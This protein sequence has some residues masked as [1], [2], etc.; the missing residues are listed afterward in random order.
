[1]NVEFQMRA[2]SSIVKSALSGVSLFSGGGIGDLALRACNIDVLVGSELLTD[3]AEI[4]K[5]NYPETEMI[6]GDILRTRE[7]ILQKAKEKLDGRELDVLFATPPCQGMSKNGRGKLLN[8]IR[9]GTKPEFDVR[10]QLALEA[11]E[12]A[13]VLKPRMIVFEN[14][15][16][17]ANTLIVRKDGEVAGLLETLADHLGPEYRGQW[18]VVE[19]ADYG[20]PERRQRLITVFSREQSVKQRIEA[21]ISLIAE[22]THSAEPTIFTKRWVSV[23]EALQG[24]PLLDASTCDK[25][26]N[27]ELEFHRVPVLDAKKYFWVSNTPMGSGA[28]DN[29][30]VNPECMYQLNPTHGAAHDDAGINRSKKDTPIRCIQCGALLPRPWVEENGDYRLMSGFTSA[31]RRMRGDLPASAL[32]K[33]LA[34][35]CS[36]HKLH[37][38]EHRVLSL[39]EAFV[40]HTVSQYPFKWIRA[41][42][43]RVT[44]TTI[45]EI[46]GESIPPKGLEVLFHH[47]L[48]ILD[49]EIEV[50]NL[51]APNE[52]G[53]CHG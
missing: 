24:L 22:K 38:R 9:A 42:G 5:A 11:L 8:G 46:L 33:N 32:T 16:E 17:M 43:K 39:H 14:V 34:F 49:S 45:R 50:K 48:G 51:V 2:E 20:V 1:M 21:D 36:D 27:Q 19:F 4:Y 40:L 12:I 28:F 44:D 31:Y 35:A 30:C 6:Q 52:R 3:R 23:N 53:V 10:N 26:T 15:P 18:E 7:E 37:P 47:L 13:L 41:D 25:A 29:Q